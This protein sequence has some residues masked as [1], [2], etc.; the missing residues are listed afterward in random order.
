MRLRPGGADRR[1][2]LQIVGRRA[3]LVDGGAWPESERTSA[4]VFIGAATRLRRGELE[5]LATD[6]LSDRQPETGARSCG[7]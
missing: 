7:D 1:G 6:C 2:I 4:L 3:D 5:A